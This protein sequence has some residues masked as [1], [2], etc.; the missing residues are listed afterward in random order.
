MIGFGFDVELLYLAQKA[1][2]RMREIPVRWNHCEG[3]KIRVV[4]DSVHMLREILSLRRGAD[5]ATLAAA[6]ADSKPGV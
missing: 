4:R 2:L 6:S 1:H 3:S 5:G